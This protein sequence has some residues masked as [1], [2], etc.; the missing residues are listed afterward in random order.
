MSLR[1][2]GAALALLPLLGACHRDEQPAPVAHPHYELGDAWQGTHGWFYPNE[3]FDYRTTGLATRQQ[4]P[5]SGLSADGEAWSAAGMTGAHQTLQLPAIVSVRNLLNG[6]IVRIRLTD[7]GPADPGRIIALSPKAA[8]LLGMTVDTPVEVTEDEAASRALAEGLVK[9]PVQN[10][11]A[12]PVGEVRETSLS[13]GSSRV[14]G[15]DSS[16]ATASVSAGPLPVTW[17][18]GSPGPSGLYVVMGIFSGHAAAAG[19]AMRCGGTVL[20]AS[21]GAGLEWRVLGGPYSDIAQAD[22]ALDHTRLCGVE[23]ARIIVE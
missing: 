14:Y 4:A 5:A 2:Y 9:A 21:E 18:Q 12:A 7:R 22:A 11:S 6:R 10:I 8:D 20:H 15:N 3:Q 17:M 16:A 1:S 23:G 19:V 13:D